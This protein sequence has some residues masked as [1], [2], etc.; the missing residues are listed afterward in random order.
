MDELTFYQKVYLEAIKANHVDPHDTALRAAYDLR[1]ARDL[2]Y[3]VQTIN[4]NTN[5]TID[6]VPF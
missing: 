4:T 3:P 5:Q 6:D 1:T 2:L